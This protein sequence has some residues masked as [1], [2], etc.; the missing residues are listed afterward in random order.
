MP[1]FK[2]KIPLLVKKRVVTS[3]VMT[4][5]YI[6]FLQ[7]VNKASTIAKRKEFSL[8][9]NICTSLHDVLSLVSM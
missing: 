9:P 5:D 8:I 3:G 1:L 7:A 2:S 6:I 4:S